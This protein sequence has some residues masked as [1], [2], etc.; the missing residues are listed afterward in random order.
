MVFFPKIM[1]KIERTLHEQNISKKHLQKKS[2]LEHIVAV[3]E[4]SENM[5]NGSF[6]V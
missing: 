2:S 5:E 3:L 6:F 4:N 1:E